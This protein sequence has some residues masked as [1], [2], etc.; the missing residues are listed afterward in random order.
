MKD[1]FKE[2]M[3]YV[4][5]VLEDAGY[6]PYDQLYAYA[7]TGNESYITRKGDARKLIAQLDRE[8][9]WDYIAPHVKQ[10]GR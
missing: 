2:T 8:Q 10:K 7:S 5:S 4:V 9:I 6:E 3:G 1:K